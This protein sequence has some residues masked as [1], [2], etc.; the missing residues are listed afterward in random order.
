MENWQAILFD[1]MSSSA[2]YYVVAIYNIAWIFLGNFILLNLFLA[3]LLDSY[4]EEQE[5]FEDEQ[6]MD[7]RRQKKIDKKA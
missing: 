5:E 7:L 3:I 4:L 1:Q 6:Q 2:G